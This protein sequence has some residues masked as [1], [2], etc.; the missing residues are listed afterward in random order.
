[1]LSGA[2]N[3]LIPGDSATATAGGVPAEDALSDF[4][5]HRP[6]WKWLC[7]A[8]HVVKSRNVSEYSADGL[9]R[10]VATFRIVSRLKAIIIVV[11]SRKNNSGTYPSH[12]VRSLGGHLIHLRP[13]SSK[14][15]F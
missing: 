13:R 7:E 3:R 11:H 1:M 14:E 15:N 10:T 8:G 5:A 4:A 6:E 9:W 2:L 12:S